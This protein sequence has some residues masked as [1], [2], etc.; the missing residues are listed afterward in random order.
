MNREKIPMA[1][2]YSDHND[3]IMALEN[4]SV[5]ADSYKINAEGNNV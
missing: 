3:L 2:E 4:K 1:N 5:P